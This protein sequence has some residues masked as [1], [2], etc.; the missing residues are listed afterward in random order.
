MVPAG[1]N[2]AT[3]IQKLLEH[4]HMDRKDTYAFGDSNNDLE[5]LEYVQY[6][7]AMGN[8]YPDVLKKARYRTDTIQEQGIYKGLKKFGLIAG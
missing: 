6:G 4:L 2:K 3:G 1:H 7:I 8:A 5:M